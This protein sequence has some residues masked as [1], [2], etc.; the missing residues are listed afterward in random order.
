M[1]GNDYIEE[2]ENHIAEIESDWLEETFTKEER[3]SALL[4]RKSIDDLKF[5]ND[6]NSYANDWVQT[7]IIERGEQ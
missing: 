4:E 3:I 5:S 1:N 2:I 7:H 6:F